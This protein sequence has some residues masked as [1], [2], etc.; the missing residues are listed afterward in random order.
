LIYI[1]IDNEDIIIITVQQYSDMNFIMNK[2]EESDV[3]LPPEITRI[4]GK[5][6][7]E[8]WKQFQADERELRT[9]KK[10]GIFASH[11]KPPELVIVFFFIVLLVLVFQF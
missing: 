4:Y 7:E 11:W 3:D 10:W 9:I 1:V 2:D 6:F 5:R 8:I